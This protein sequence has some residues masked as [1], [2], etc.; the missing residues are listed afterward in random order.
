MK[1]LIKAD[2]TGIVELL[3]VYWTPAS[4]EQTLDRLRRGGDFLFLARRGRGWLSDFPTVYTPGTEENRIWTY[5]IA[6]P[7]IPVTALFLHVDNSIEGRPWGS[8]TILDYPATVTDIETFSPLPQA[9][10]ERHIRLMIR[11]YLRNPRYCCLLEV[12]QYLKSGGEC[13]WM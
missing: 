9:Q 13:Q 8:V 10:R 4:V 12:I 1:R 3:P 6:F 11:R 5:G 2:L 7:H